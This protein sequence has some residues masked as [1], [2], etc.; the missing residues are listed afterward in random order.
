MS[1]PLVRGVFALVVFATIA[2]FFVTQQ[3]KS[4]FP[5]VIRFATAPAQF[6]PNADGFRDTSQVGFDLSEP[7]TLSFEITD[8]EGNSVRRLVDERHL[9]GDEKYRFRWDGRDDEG[10][11]VPDGTY[12]MRVVRR[13]ESRVIDSVKEITVDRRPP[14]VELLSARPSVIA[15]EAPV[16]IRYRGPRN[17]APEFRVFRTDDGPPRVVRRFRGDNSRSGLWKGGVSAGPDATRPAEDGDYTFTVTVRDRAG[18]LAVAPTEIPRRGLTRPGTGV[19]VERL[20]LRGPLDVVHAG[21][22]V[23][24]EV[25]P[26]ERSFDFVL[27]RFGTPR[28]IRRGRRVGGALRMGIPGTVETGLY[29]VRVRSGKRRAVWPVA[30]EGRSRGKGPRPLLVLPAISWQGLNPVDDDHDG[31]AD[32]LP[33][34]GP[35]TVDRHFAGGGLPPRFAAEVSPLLR[36]LDRE[37]LDYD[38]TTDLSL[39]L[40]EGPALE[41]APG[42]A[43]AGSTLWLPGPLLRQLRGYVAEGHPLASFGADAFRRTVRLRA[44]TLRDPSRRRAE[45]AF[46]ERT[47]L[48]RTGAS[49]LAVLQDD[50]GLFQGLP[51]PVGDFELFERSRGL[52]EDARPL[53]LAGPA[54]NEPAFV[55]YELGRGMV[56]RSG[57]PQWAG[58]LAAMGV[59][60][61]LVTRRIWRRLAPGGTG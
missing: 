39:A 26:L 37:R 14:A 53:S 2:A 19:S 55:A 36:F 50:L 16:R 30:V 34:G 32:T 43:F 1:R 49:P 52:A 27:S 13:D 3:L 8:A 47:T 40:G 31:F 25:G 61:P 35:V 23:E 17:A 10:E 46:G 4:E 44:D 7:A 57:S 41:D 15:D 38:L 11:P 33:Q 9:A 18:N 45:D 24:L 6:S 29:L 54:P 51:G 22:T 42:A 59:E 48:V 20:T 21:S 12:R 5:L 28:P 60:V 58:E 56:V